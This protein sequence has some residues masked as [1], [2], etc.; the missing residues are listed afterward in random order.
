[1]DCPQNYGTVNKKNRF[2]IV[3]KENKAKWSIIENR[4]KQNISDQ[5]K[6]TFTTKTNI[7]KCNKYDTNHTVE[8]KILR[9][10]KK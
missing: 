7:P 9:I 3:V 5:H 4:Q 1:M 8:Y 2:M 6:H 10:S